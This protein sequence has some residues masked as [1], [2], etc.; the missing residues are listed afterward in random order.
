MLTC[1]VNCVKQHKEQTGC[2][3]VKETE[4][5]GRIKLRVNEMNVTGLRKEMKFL[6]DGINLSNKAK[7][8]NTLARAGIA[9]GLVTKQVDPKALKK[10]KNLKSF[11]KKK[12]AIHYYMS[13]SSAF[14]R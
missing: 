3:G 12:R 5:V 9:N 10:Q 11:L 8:D 7:K 4:Q 6:E 13:P 1:S 2:S 14:K